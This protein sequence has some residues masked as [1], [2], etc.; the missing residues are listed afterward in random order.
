MNMKPTNPKDAAAMV[1]LAAVV[2]ILVVA[3]EA[4]HWLAAAQRALTS[5]AAILAAVGGAVALAL[6]AAARTHAVRRALSRRVA[7]QLVPAGSFDPGVEAV[8][9]FA[10]GLARSRRS[11]SGALLAPAYAVRVR[12]D[13]DESGRLRYTVELPAHAKRALVT[14]AGAYADGVELREV[15]LD[16]KPPDGE[17][18]DPPTEVARAELVLAR[19]SHEPLREAGLDPDPLATFA[20]ALS[21]LQ[22]EAGEQATVCLDLLPVTPAGRRRAR[23]R[24]LRRVRR[25]QRAERERA[26]VREMF[27]GGSDCGPSLPAELVDRQASQSALRSKLGRSEPMFY[28]QIL[29]RTASPDPGAAQLRLDGLL[30]AFDGFAG[31]NHF[32]VAGLNLGGA[33]FAGADA[34]WRRG[35]FERRFASCHFAPTRKR[36]VTASEIAGLLKPP[37]AKCPAPNVVRSGGMVPPPPPGLPTFTGQRELLPLGKVSEDGRERLVGVPLVDTFFS[38]TAGRT[39]YGKTE[40]AIGQ[41][42]H[43][44]RSGHGC[45]FLDPHSDALEKIKP[46][47][48]TEELRDR[49]V[50]I[51]LADTGRQPGWNL[52]AL[53]EASEQRAQDRVDAVVDSFASALRWDE[54]NTRALNLI[55]QAAQALSELARK[56]PPELGPTIFQVPT[57]L[58]N[59]EWRGA[60]LR[61]VSP[62]TR[63]FFNERFPRLAAE[64]ITPV[65]NLID[66]LRVSPPVA[67][68]LGSPTSSYDVR[69]AMDEGKIVLACPGQGSVRDRL[70]ANFLVYDL[71]HA[72]KSRAS[73]PPDERRPFYVFLDEV[74]T[75]DGAS[76]GNLA[77]LL[78]Q[79]AKYGVR[80]LLFNQSPERLTAQT[81]N[82]ITTNRSHLLTTALGSKAAGMVAREWSGK[83][84]PQM[85]AGLPRYSFCASVTLAAEV[86]PPFLLRGVPVE[87]LFPDEARPQHLGELDAA[88]DANSGRRSC[89]RTVARL[90][91]HDRAILSYLRQKAGR[92]SKRRGSDDGHG[93]HAI[94]ERGARERGER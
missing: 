86:S 53:A 43:L 31:E 75:Y 64:A 50:E 35:R 72:A 78:E 68:L 63:A 90:D 81:L 9:R 1:T 2:A 87:E 61:F 34:P 94:G 38:Y 19:A 79:S 76:S 77:A 48:T 27:G 73:M 32:R 17:P 60:V 44:A 65:T 92:K 45:F 4:G 89:A 59:E 58:G 66:R 23:R 15:P 16:P 84:E 57:L 93:T 7:V 56:L 62:P 20:R 37:S 12:L 51:N 55:T 83:V 46:Y 6:L 67:A 21:G 36:L 69:A 5:P 13:T 18:G 40:S 49:V 91:E 24:L 80:A 70:V 47:L 52:F 88:I 22:V 8:V 10:A 85:I 11:V 3:N 42:L 71:L 29:V 82:A 26:S 41:F 14:A 28:P 33:V 30:A 54:T 74:Q 25:Q 39:R